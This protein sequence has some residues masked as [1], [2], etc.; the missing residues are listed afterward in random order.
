MAPISKRRKACKGN[1][2]KR[3]AR[4]ANIVVSS[5]SDLN[6]NEVLEE[7]IH[8]HSVKFISVGT[9]TDSNPL[10][11]YNEKRKEC[12]Y[13]YHGMISVVY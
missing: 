10:N 1:W 9:Q 7:I 4:K 8:P 3:L 5:N 13:H 11:L 2:N 12:L 6:N